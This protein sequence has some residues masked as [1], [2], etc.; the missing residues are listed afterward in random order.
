MVRP[1]RSL[2]PDARLRHEV[3][4]LL[5]GRQAHVDAEAALGGVP[6]DRVD[7]RAGGEHSLWELAWHLRFT[8]ADILRFATSPDYEEPAWPDAYWPGGPAPPGGWD[9]T[10][11]AFLDDRDALVDLA[12]AG[13]L[14]AELAWSPGYTLLRELLLA[15]DHAAYH[16]G[17]VVALR[18]RLGLWPP[19]A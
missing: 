3:A 18:R 19:Q 5:R 16:L 17:E 6:L 1:P 15:A 7:D 2:D 14:T 9:E 4:A 12:H 8:Q 13:D 11:R 10:V